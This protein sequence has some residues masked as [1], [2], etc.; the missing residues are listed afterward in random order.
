MFQQRSLVSDYSLGFAIL[1]ILLMIVENELASAN[2]ITKV[3]IK[4]CIHV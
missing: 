3:T 2:V 1:G 4:F